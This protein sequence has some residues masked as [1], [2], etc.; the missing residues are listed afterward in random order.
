MSKPFPIRLIL[1]SGGARG[2]AHIGV[3]KELENRNCE[4]TEIIGCSMG[5]LIGG[6]YCAGKLDAYEDWV[7]NL[8]KWDVFRFLDI[9]LGNRDGIMKGDMIIE[10]LRELVGDRDIEDLPIPFTAVATDIGRRQEVWLD[11]GNLFD[12]I[13]A[14]IAVPG[15]FTPKRINGRV[16]VDG[17]LLNPL[18]GAPHDAEQDS[19]TIAVSLSGRDMTEPLGPNPPAPPESNIDRYRKAVD[20]FLEKAQDALGLEKDSGKEEEEEEDDLSLTGVMLGMFDTM[21]AQIARFRLAS[22]PPDVLI[23]I[24]GNVCQ[25]HEYF[26][27][28]ALIHAGQYWASDALDRQLEMIA[29]QNGST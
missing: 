21:Q 23:E 16:L 19:V 18:P 6:F 2:L 11:S 5:A 17:G 28:R 7:C 22:Y 29:E 27:A 4:I 24:P 13:R 8:D 1:G 26:K 9:S 3:I 14:S 10:A 15:V 20:E 12:A 25:T